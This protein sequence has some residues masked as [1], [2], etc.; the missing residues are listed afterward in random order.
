MSRDTLTYLS[1]TGFIALYLVAAR[2]RRVAG[3]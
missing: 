1:L 3:W 2:F